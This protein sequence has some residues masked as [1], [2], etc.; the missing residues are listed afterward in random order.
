MGISIIEIEQKPKSQNLTQTVDQ[1]L[2]S[3]VASA[4]IWIVVS[5]GILS[6][7]GH[8]APSWQTYLPFFFKALLGVICLIVL[9]EVLWK[10]V[11]LA[12]LTP[13]WPKLCPNY[14]RSGVVFFTL[15]YVI[16]PM[17]ISL[18]VLHLQLRLSFG[19]WMG[20]VHS[21]GGL[22]VTLKFLS[23]YAV[24][25]AVSAWIGYFLFISQELLLKGVAL[26]WK[27]NERMRLLMS[28]LSHFIYF[29]CIPFLIFFRQG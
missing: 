4:P 25:C 11:G 1:V 26:V 18:F 24:L 12:L 15:K 13:L 19:S 14:S 10:K 23:V 29:L 17:V 28:L 6:Q 3:G 27:K 8:E 16:F 2:F 21:L 9:R 20:G 22:G 7:I 5:S